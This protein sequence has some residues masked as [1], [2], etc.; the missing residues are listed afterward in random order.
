V[1]TSA[2]KIHA[3]QLV[4]MAKQIQIEEVRNSMA[5]QH[6][7]KGILEMLNTGEPKNLVDPTY[8]V[9]GSFLSKEAQDALRNKLQ[10]LPPA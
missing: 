9:N 5:L 6:P 2:A 7:Q 10:R 1:I 8:M 4:E 3:G